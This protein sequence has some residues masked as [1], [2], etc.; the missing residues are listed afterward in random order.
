MNI[1]EKIVAL[2]TKL[3]GKTIKNV[4]NDFDYPNDI[5]I[6]EFT[7]NTKLSIEYDWIYEVELQE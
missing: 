5:M 7:D 3:K 4:Y 6:I 2:D 1:H